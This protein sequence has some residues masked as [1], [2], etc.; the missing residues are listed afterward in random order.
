M[1]WWIIKKKVCDKNELVSTQV[2]SKFPREKQSIKKWNGSRDN[3][4]SHFWIQKTCSS[5]RKDQK[6][7]TKSLR[8]EIKSDILK[9]QCPKSINVTDKEWNKGDC[10]SG[11]FFRILLGMNI[12]SIDT[13]HQFKFKFVS[14]QH[15]KSKWINVT[16]KLNGSK[17]KKKHLWVEIDFIRV[18][19]W[20]NERTNRKSDCT[21]EEKCYAAITFFHCFHRK[22]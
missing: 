12:I 8:R 17:K 5:E 11:F 21:F 18:V 19:L 16:F 7:G 3:E 13:A 22:F 6:H 10:M 14:M 2:A 4:D 9:G 1:Q 20:L 15:L